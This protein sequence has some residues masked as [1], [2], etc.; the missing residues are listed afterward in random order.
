LVG[1]LYVSRGILDT[2]DERSFLF[3]KDSNYSQ[4][5]QCHTQKPW[6]FYYRRLTSLIR[7]KGDQTKKNA[8]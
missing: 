5:T 8:Q 1:T 7:S 6:I 3:R 2:E 4:C